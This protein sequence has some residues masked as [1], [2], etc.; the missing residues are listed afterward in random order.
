M[1]AFFFLYIILIVYALLIRF[2]SR[3]EIR[4]KRV[5]KIYKLQAVS[6]VIITALTGT[7][8]SFLFAQHF[9]DWLYQ[10]IPTFIVAAIVS[11]AK[12]V[13]LQ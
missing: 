10:L 8:I 9:T 2:A 3:H 4:A 11:V 12:P 5:G 13:K 6:V 7:S 1:G